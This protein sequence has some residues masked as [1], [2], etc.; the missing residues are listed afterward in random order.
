MCSWRGHTPGSQVLL[1]ATDRN[2]LV[3]PDTI[4]T[5]K[6]MYGASEPIRDI[7]DLS[8][9]TAGA[10]YGGLAPGELWV[11]TPGPGTAT[12][13]TQSGEVSST[14]KP[15][16][17]K[18]ALVL[19][20]ITGAWVVENRKS[21]ET[22]LRASLE[23]KD[24]EVLTVIGISVAERRRRGRALQDGADSGEEG[25]GGVRIDYVVGFSDEAAATTA[26]AKIELLESGSDAGAVAMLETFVTSL[27]EALVEAGVAPVALSVADVKPVPPKVD[28]ATAGVPGG[29]PEAGRGAEEEP[30]PRKKKTPMTMVLLIAGMVFGGVVALAAIFLL[31]RRLLRVVRGKPR[32][33]ATE[34]AS[35][36][37]DAESADGGKLAK[38]DASDGLPLPKDGTVPKGKE[39]AFW[40]RPFFFRKTKKGKK[41]EEEGA[42]G[43]RGPEQE[44]EPDPDDYWGTMVDSV[45]SPQAAQ[46]EDDW[47]VV[48]WWMHQGGDGGN[49]DGGPFSQPFFPGAGGYGYDYDPNAAFPPGGMLPYTMPPYDP[50]NPGNPPYALADYGDPEAGPPPEAS[51][52]SEWS[53]PAEEGP[54]ELSVQ[55]GANGP[56][57]SAN[58]PEDVDGSASEPLQAITDG[59]ASTPSP[60]VAPKK[61]AAAPQAARDRKVS[62]ERL[63]GTTQNQSRTPETRQ[64][65]RTP[66]HAQQRVARTNPNTISPTGARGSVRTSVVERAGQPGGHHRPTGPQPKRTPAKR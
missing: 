32:T 41:M 34:Y 52:S 47:W 56:S 44:P 8:K 64:Q 18:G 6:S 53:R 3:F 27:D 4:P 36:V 22:A 48:P 20:G 14:G 13:F 39:G 33:R 9:S 28:A 31:A 63:I 55:G 15:F 62:P 50:D 40:G 25:G 26:G 5:G 45:W 29:V 1:H 10:S 38:E 12:V 57:G 2:A 24:A 17:V 54:T 51:A 7:M 66:L 58:S 23:L 30:V 42:A 19:S 37:A 60:P 49:V 35:R 16:E 43:S 21:V 59:S 11:Q 65:G 46:A 61:K